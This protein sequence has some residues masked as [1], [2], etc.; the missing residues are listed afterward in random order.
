[1]HQWTS[2]VLSHVC[3]WVSVWAHGHSAT[4][5]PMENTPN[6]INMTW[7]EKKVASVCPL[8]RL[9]ECVMHCIFDVARHPACIVKGMFPEMSLLYLILSKSWQ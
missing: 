3:I 1:M 4:M 9:L 7:I 6:K 2:G 8:A 5:K